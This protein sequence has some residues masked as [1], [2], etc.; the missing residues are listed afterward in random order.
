MQLFKIVIALISLII[1]AIAIASNLSPIVTVVVLNQS[2]VMLPVGVWLAIAI[3]LGLLSSSAIQFLIWLQQQALTKRVRQLQARLTDVGEDVFTYTQAKPPVSDREFVT[4]NF[5]R[6]HPAPKD[7]TT[8]PVNPR[9]IDN[10]DD[11]E[12]EPTV[13]A[14]AEWDD[15]PLPR[16]QAV[17]SNRRDYIPPRQQTVKAPERNYIDEDP[18]DSGDVYDAAFRLI[19]PPYKSPPP[20]AEADEEDEAY[21]EEI[22]ADIPAAS[23]PTPKEDSDEED[24]GFDFDDTAPSQTRK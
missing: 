23:T 17:E 15:V 3:G 1:L 5:V 19:Q 20:E 7:F 10:S 14:P 9:A 22:E 12:Q 21:E 18:D 6:P 24:W 8:S 2:T 4:E 16:Q 11:W 13:K